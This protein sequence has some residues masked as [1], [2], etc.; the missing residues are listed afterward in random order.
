MHSD[1]CS[2]A[3][4]TCLLLGFDESVQLLWY[5]EILLKIS[6]YSCQGCIQRYHVSAY[7]LLCLPQ[8]ST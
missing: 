2:S 4:R 6:F 7:K 5:T 1:A 8:S 3:V